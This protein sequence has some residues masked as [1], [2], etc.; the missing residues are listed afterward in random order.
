M[1]KNFMDKLLTMKEAYE[2]TGL[3]RTAFNQHIRPAVPH[4]KFGR[5]ILFKKEDLDAFFVRLEAK[6]ISPTPLYE[7]DSLGG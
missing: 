1:N 3:R 6:H 4:F 2:Y 5:T 7:N